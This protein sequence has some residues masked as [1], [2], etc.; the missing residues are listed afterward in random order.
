MPTK[1][2]T[3]EFTDVLRAHQ[4]HAEARQLGKAKMHVVSGYTSETW[5]VEVSTRFDK[6]VERKTRAAAK[7]H[8]R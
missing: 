6:I 5:Q 8:K 7:G 3:Y 4:F 1:Y 2:V